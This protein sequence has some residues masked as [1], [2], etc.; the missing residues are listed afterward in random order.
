[1]RYT[2]H[3]GLAAVTRWVRLKYAAM[4]LKKLANWSWNSLLFLANITYFC[5]RY[6]KAPVLAHRKLGFFDRLKG[7]ELFA[8]SLFQLVK[9]LP[10]RPHFLYN[11]GNGGV[12]V[13][14]WRKDARKEAIIIDIDSLVPA[15]HLLRRIE[16]VMDYEWLYERLEPYYCHDNGRPGT[17]PVV[18]IRMVFFSIYSES[19]LYGRHIG[20][21]R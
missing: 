12:F 16:K 15:D 20:R 3:R 1:M 18:L 8:Q 17:D 2:H 7:T 14:Q 10:K 4:N 11:R 9:K 21:F 19:L 5:P 13:E 6:A